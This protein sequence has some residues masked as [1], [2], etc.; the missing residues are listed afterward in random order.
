M[1]N[2]EDADLMLG[3]GLS[4]NQARANLVIPKLE[5]T[6]VGQARAIKWTTSRLFAT[7]PPY[8]G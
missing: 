2:H 6:T 8:V 7:V 5:K 1:S 4:L 3:L